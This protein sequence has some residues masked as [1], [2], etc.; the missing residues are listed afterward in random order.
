MSR[1][2]AQ[3]T[4]IYLLV[5]VNGTI[6][7][8]FRMHVKAD[9]YVFEPNPVH[10]A[11]DLSTVTTN[12]SPSTSGSPKHDLIY[13]PQAWRPAATVPRYSLPGHSENRIRSGWPST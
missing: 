8:N 9:G 2:R 10:S 11:P 12:L 13:G 4:A 3:D 7:D 6:P 5:A 1:R